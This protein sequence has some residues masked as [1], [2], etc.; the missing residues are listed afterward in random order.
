MEKLVIFVKYQ[1]EFKSPHKIQ[2]FSNKNKL[3]FQLSGAI[4]HF[5]KISMRIETETIILGGVD[6]D[7]DF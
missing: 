3:Y 6:E 1:I 7:D 2:D 4:L 5:R